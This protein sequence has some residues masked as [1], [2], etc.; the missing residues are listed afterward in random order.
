M[1]YHSK[2]KLIC[3]LVR[4][5]LVLA[6]GCFCSGLSAQQ[7]K[8]DSEDLELTTS[9]DVTIHATISLPEHDEAMPAVILIHQ[10]GSDRSEWNDYLAKFHAK[11]MITLAYDV[12]GHGDNERI[13]NIRPL[14]DDPDLAPADLKA[15]LEYL[16]EHEQ[17]DSERIAVV[18][19]SI[20]SNLACVASS[21]MGIKTAVAI[22]GKTSAVYNLAGKEELELKSIFHI[23]SEGDQGGA[24][25]KFA[26]ELYE[27]TAEPRKIEIIKG[28]R[29]HGVSIFKD[30]PELIDRVIDWLVETLPIK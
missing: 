22:S 29:A 20:G 21:E 10:G 3:Q 14:F 13:R 8:V 19:A 26:Q 4:V 7:V 9:D 17:V 25:V 12:R 24:R 27:E 30:D 1:M 15:A 23:S 6:C 5:S 2:Q 11:H 28:S 16:S 18:G